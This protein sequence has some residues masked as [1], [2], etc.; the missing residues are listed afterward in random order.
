MSW[1]K[2]QKAA[3]LVLIILLFLSTSHVVLGSDYNDVAVSEAKNMVD[4]W[5]PLVI[6][7][8]RGQSEYN[9]GHIKNA[10]LIPH[11]Q[12]EG[13][14][15]ELN[16][17]NRI[18]VYCKLG[19]RSAIASQILADN[20]FPFIY[21][22]L[23]GIT[24]WINAGYP[25]YVLFPS[26]QEAIN[27]AGE[28]ETL[29][30]S[31]GVYYEHISLNKMLSL[32]GENIETA[33]IDGENTGVGVAITANNSELEGF[34]IQSTEDYKITIIDCR[35]VQV[36]A[37]NLIGGYGI[38]VEDSTNVSIEE[39]RLVNCSSN[40]ISFRSSTNS[41]LL[42]N[43]VIGSAIG[44]PSP[45]GEGC[46]ISL[47][48]SSMNL[49]DDNS[50]LDNDHAISL[51][52]A[53]NN[54]ISHNTISDA[55]FEDIYS[56]SGIVLSN[57]SNN[58]T[59][60]NNEVSEMALQGIILN[61]TD[62]NSLVRNLIF[63]NGEHGLWLQ[64][65]NGNIIKGN[66]IENNGHEAINLH[67]SNS[68]RIFHNSFINNNGQIVLTGSPSNIWDDDY[69]SG[70]NYWSNYNGSDLYCGIYQNETGSDNIGDTPYFLDGYNKD[71][72]PLMTPE[73]LPW[74]V[75]D[76]GY[77]GIDDII[78][79]AE[80]FGDAPSHPD[81]N[82]KYDLN[83]DDYVGIDDIVLVAVHFGESA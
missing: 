12:L 45:L 43:M 70:G 58:N 20:G 79:V 14:L 10:K 28:G 34:T 55:I 3:S 74:D 47:K 39:N 18:L 36:K 11:D 78:L 44:H 63:N 60:I 22:M 19:G 68:N 40:G 42:S 38:L 56:L 76:D 29:Y 23:G 32:K 69:P 53:E 77:V 71:N 82:P 30:V 1:R 66:L 2:M 61:A 25:A 48:N 57:S 27:D 21:N 80:H 67:D 73:R 65:S 8:V 33:I 37:N 64:W 81:W 75:T 46:A 54:I 62:N 9:T 24:A 17:S 5:D 13:R 50:I 6:L 16:P 59:I 26:I 15:D 31:S 41:R 83:K 7:D 72:Y 49:V 4:N 52:N 51:D 35:D